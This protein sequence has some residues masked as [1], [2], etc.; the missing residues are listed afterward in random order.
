MSYSFR[1]PRHVFWP[2]LLLFISGLSP[3]PCRAD[4]WGISTDQLYSRVIRF[5]PVTGE[6]LTGGIP[7][8]TPGLSRPSGIAIGPDGRMY[9]SSRGDDDA[10]SP[11]IQIFSCDSTGSCAPDTLPGGEPGVFV[12]FA[13]EPDGAQ[14]SI[15]RFGPDGILHVSELFLVGGDEVRVYDPVDGTRLP[16]SASN[17]P[18]AGGITFEPNGDLL[19]GTLAVPD[20]LIPATISRFSAGQQQQP[21]FVATDDE[22]RFAASMLFLPNGDLLAVDLLKD[23]IARFGSDGQ[24]LGTFATIPTIIEGKP[25]FPSDI[26]FD[27]DGNLIVAVLGPN[28]PGDEGGNQGQLLRYGLN[29]NL[30]EVIEEELEQIGGLAWTASPLTTAGDF[31][32]GGGV[33]GAD[34]AKWAADFGKWVAPGNGADGNGDGVVN[35]ADYIVWRKAMSAGSAPASQL[36]IPEPSAAALLLAG[37]GVAATTLRRRYCRLQRR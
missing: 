23:E 21:F 9:V 2:V 18:G 25:S 30:L 1:P 7:T 35:A 28:N 24:H 20:F 13:G 6:E 8:G 19:V 27:P 4:L 31:H 15:L 32:P 3:T 10:I 26:V 29:G 5:N 33:D 17:L 14:P 16:N 11:K 12:D 22:I 36:G 37:L 34:Y